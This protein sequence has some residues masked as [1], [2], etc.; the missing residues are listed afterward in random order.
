MFKTSR[1]VLSCAAVGLALATLSCTSETPTL[2]KVADVSST[3]DPEVS[4]KASAPSLV[5]PPDGQTIIGRPRLELSAATGLVSGVTFSYQF[6]ISNDGGSVVDTSTV[7]NTVLD[8]SGTLVNQSAYT[9][10]A[11]AARDGQFFGPWSSRRTFKTGALPGCINGFLAEPDTF[12]FYKINR[13]KGEQANDWEAVLRATGWPAGYAPGI[14]PPQGP[15]FYGLATQISSNGTYRSRMF[16][17]AAT[18]DAFGFF[19]REIDTLANCPGGFCWKWDD[20]GGGAYAPS[21]CP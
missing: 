20:K 15:P 8:Y 18:P 14:R 19:V 16:I 17:P 9:W 4:L 6:E 13:Q 2:P 12:F 3:V 21:T 5:S 10:R 11:R 7:D 1:T